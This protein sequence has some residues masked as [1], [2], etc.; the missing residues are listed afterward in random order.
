MLI[1]AGVIY[2]GILLILLLLIL[3]PVGY[4]VLV[5]AFSNLQAA[6]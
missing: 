3:F 6:P 5:S 1:I 4:L 2:F